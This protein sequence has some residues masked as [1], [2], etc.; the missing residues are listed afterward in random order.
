MSGTKAVLIADWP[1]G[2]LAGGTGRLYLDTGVSDEQQGVL[3]PVPSGQ[4]GGEFEGVASLISNL[5]PTTRAAIAF[6]DDGDDV[7]FTVEGVGDGVFTP[8]RGPSG[9]ATRVLHGAAAF[10]E[11][12]SWA[13]A[14][15]RAST[16][17][18]CGSGRAGATASP[19]E[20]DW[21]G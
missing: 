17:R 10:R 4:R 18:T 7:R 8:R 6:S 14:W 11:T 3:E 16:T 21:S 15:G 9:E 5:L 13:R 12:P 20:F 2:F 19:A 1:R